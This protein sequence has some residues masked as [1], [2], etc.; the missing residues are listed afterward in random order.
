MSA[1][2]NP[3]GRGSRRAHASLEFTAPQERRPTRLLK[4]MMSLLVLVLVLLCPLAR[5]ADNQ[6]TDAEQHQGWLLLF[7]GKTLDGWMTSASQPGKTPV[8][9]SA[10]NPHRSGAYMLVHTQQWANFLLTLDFKITNGCNS[11]I[12]VRTSSLTP[13][14]GR[15][16]GFNGLEIAIDD[17]KEA[18]FHD[19]GA[20]YDLVKPT[21]NAMKPVG[22][23]NHI[24]IACLGS[25]IEVA[26]NG[27]PVTRA[28]LDLFNRPGVRPD[29]SAHKFD[30]AW[31]DHPRRGY[32][33]LQD[34]GS[35]CWFKN[36]KLRPLP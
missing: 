24:E 15:D 3:V 13:K 21:K 11:G 36:I 32:I 19:T 30:I 9:Q 12:F 18:G 16:V 26:L 10:L 14:P 35:P 23:W 28:D 7:D 5:A 33:G 25:R 1:P 4:R 27:E 22:E 6:L 17:T 8:E 20:V 34:H 29:G 2:L 31:K